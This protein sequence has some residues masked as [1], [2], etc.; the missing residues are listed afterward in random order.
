MENKRI[1]FYGPSG[2]GKTTMAKHISNK[3]G[4][5]FISGSISDLIPK[6][7]EL[8]HLDMM[9][10]DY[11]QI[12]IEDN[13]LFSLR[14]KNLKN[15]PNYVTDRSYL[16]IMAYH[17]VKISKGISE[18]DT[19]VLLQNIAAALMRDCTHLIFV[20]MTKDMVK[21]WKMEDND[22]RIL[23]RYFQWQVSLVM[24]G[25]LEMLDYKQNLLKKIFFNI[26]QGMIY[27][28]KVFRELN[29]NAYKN[30][31]LVYKPL[32]V[33]ILNTDDYDVRNE[34]IDEFLV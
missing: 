6:T 34:I 14:A 1:M 9:N 17:L 13:Q 2:V 18:C 21:N 27:P 11:K 16:D 4:I 22:K 28:E 25:L 20:P 26:N 12:Y 10:R 29:L 3:Y 19:D 8:S 23:N 24:R 5:P 31:Y 30:Y 7:K 15:E 32:K 33:L